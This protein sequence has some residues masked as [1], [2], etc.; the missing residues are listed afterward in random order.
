MG[1]DGVRSKNV[2]EQGIGGYVMVDI[3]GFKVFNMEIRP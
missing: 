3:T 1:T 2:L